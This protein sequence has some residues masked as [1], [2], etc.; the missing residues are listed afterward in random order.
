MANPYKTHWYDRRP[1]HWLNKE[2]AR[3]DGHLE[4]PEVIRL[5]PEIEGDDRPP[6]RIFLG[7]EPGQYRATRVFVWSVLQNRNPA[8]AYEIHLMS[9]LAGVPRE[10]WKTGFTNYR[11]LIPDL[12]GGSGRAIYN[13]VDQ[14]Y[15]TD[16]ARL[17]DMEMHDKGVLA[18]S[19]KENSVMLI[20]CAVM[21]PLWRRE[22]VAVGRKHGHFKGVMSAHGL[23]GELAE[24]WNSR[25]GA[26]PV[27]ETDCLHYTTLHTQPWKP[28]PDL[29]RYGKSPVADAWHKLERSADEAGFLLFTRERPSREAGELIAQYRL[30]HEGGAAARAANPDEPRPF[31]G[32]SL[33]KHLDRVSGLIRTSGARTIL[34]YGAGKAAA[35]QPASDADPEGAVRRF[36]GWPD[37]TVR[38]Y[39]PGHPPFSELSDDLFDGVIS[40]D[41]VEHLAPFDVA[42]VIDEIFAHARKFVYVVAA[43]YPAKKVLPNGRNAHSTVQPPYWWHAQMALASRRYPDVDWTLVCETR[44]Q[45][46][47]SR[48]IIDRNTPSPLD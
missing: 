35:Y 27:E 12:A 39:D 47:K 32:G 41:V 14:I 13:D 37:V 7:T 3:P 44:G 33:I 22:D 4:T 15:L 45:F 18:I 16:P 8:R 23:F 42:W 36:S 30:M 10:G 29:L 26:V 11:Y 19:E 28:F 24:S 17:F 21:A 48:R 40:T 34:D 20:D 46:G 31:K 25:D 5:D 43:C 9:D 38:C 1:A 2:I 6:V